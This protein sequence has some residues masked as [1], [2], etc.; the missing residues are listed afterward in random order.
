[1][2]CVLNKLPVSCLLDILEYLTGNGRQNENSEA[3][4]EGD[5]SA[6]TIE[7]DRDETTESQETT[8]DM[9][10]DLDP[11][12]N[13]YHRIDCGS[14]IAPSTNLCLAWEADGVNFFVAYPEGYR[15]LKVDP[16]FQQLQ[17]KAKKEGA[18]L[19]RHQDRIEEIIYGRWENV[20]TGMTY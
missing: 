9:C 10:F 13:E 15:R 17:Q 12:E 20:V 14:C 8:V 16:L 4:I 1:M 6:G 5:K 11:V 7:T 3:E 19:E 18:M 2:D